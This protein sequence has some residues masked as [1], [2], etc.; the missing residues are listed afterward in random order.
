MAGNYVE[1]SKV[2]AE[3]SAISLP[4][5][6]KIIGLEGAPKFI[7]EGYSAELN[8]NLPSGAY[9]EW[10]IYPTDGVE[11]NNGVNT[12][13]SILLT[14]RKDGEYTLTARVRSASGDVGMGRYMN[15]TVQN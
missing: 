1:A 2:N 13:F 7:L 10:V 11:F 12:G 3:M 5:V 4:A 14:F 8:G 9:V 6:V 15:I